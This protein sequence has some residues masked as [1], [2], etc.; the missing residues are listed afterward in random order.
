[1]AN[2]R[3]VEMIIAAKNATGAVFDA[4]AKGLGGVGKAAE[5]A[6]SALG[7]TSSQSEAAGD[8]LAGVGK[9]GAATGGILAK[10]K[11][12]A[13]SVAVALGKGAKDASE[14]GKSA[15]GAGS[16]GVNVLL[17]NMANLVTVGKGVLGMLGSVSGAIGESLA[18]S[19][20]RGDQGVL[21]LY[22]AMGKAKQA[23]DKVIGAVIQQ[24]VPSLSPLVNML[25]S[26]AEATANWIQESRVVET[27]LKLT[28]S[29][30]ALLLRGV[31]KAIVG[32]EALAAVAKFAF[33][34]AMGAV[35]GAIAKTLEVLTGM[36]R[37]AAVFSQ[38]L[39]Q[40][41]ADSLFRTMDRLDKTAKAWRASSNAAEEA[42]IG[43]V[44]TETALSGVADAMDKAA[45][46]IGK[47]TDAGKD[48]SLELLAY[49]EQGQ[50]RL[51]ALMELELAQ[52]GENREKRIAIFRK[53][54]D[55]ELQTGRENGQRALEL[56]KEISTLET[57]ARVA[58]IQARYAQEL[59]LAGDSAADQVEI[60]ERYIED[61][62]ELF[63]PGS[64]QVLEAETSMLLARQAAHEEA[65]E[66]IKETIQ[67]FWDW[68]NE[69]T[70]AW[71]DRQLEDLDF[72]RELGLQ[73][74]EI[75]QRK[76]DI[77]QEL[78]QNATVSADIRMNAEKMVTNLQKQQALQQIKSAQNTA[79]KT[80]ELFQGMA[81]TLFASGMS[82]KE[83]LLSV[84]SQMTQGIIAELGK[85]VQ[86]SI[87]SRAQQAAATQ[88]AAAAEAAA[89]GASIPPK[90]AA[91]H[92]HIPIVGPALA[93]VAL[94]LFQALAKRVFKFNSGGPVP[95]LSQG[96]SGLVPGTGF[97]DTV[98]ADLTG[99]EYVLKKESTSRLPREGLDYMNET[100]QFPPGAGGSGGAKKVMVEVGFK[101]VGDSRAARFL[102]EILEL[103]VK[104]YDM[105]VTATRFLQP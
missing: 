42:N 41:V 60:W 99:G 92:A 82:L 12:A 24:L 51:A 59:E 16:G 35:Q 48:A 105:D 28:I 91:A 52:V 87:V 20:E 11:T 22:G 75:I 32:W 78:A 4:A 94:T 55:I 50:A 63:G 88:S 102:T 103:A 9:Q 100:G 83:K 19:A 64:E 76:I 73:E 62:V 85:Q 72:Q 61:L 74:E 65:A 1:M 57:E 96:A 7:D 93:A 97:S 81:Q 45:D 2:Q 89:A 27:V 58:G 40:D 39:D 84:F 3:V 13:A 44:R 80:I 98:S 69:G 66:R 18:R 79:M 70:Q 15:K 5:E 90:V 43:Y 33:V 49:S 31:D 67:G 21:K 26:V 101:D 104:E 86:A 8:S 46:S 53:F 6:N 71:L 23:I 34:K 95:M 17:H 77:Y 68:Y 37:E 38:I 54:Y 36:I 14:F 30:L 10:L 56:Q 25:V 29:G 47:A